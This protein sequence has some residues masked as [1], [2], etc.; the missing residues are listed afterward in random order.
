MV[1]SVNSVTMTATDG[2]GKFASTTRVISLVEPAGN[3]APT[4]TF[5]VSCVALACLTSSAGTFDANGDVIRYSRNFGDASALS[6]ATSPSHTYLANGTYTITL[7]TTDARD[8]TRQLRL[9]GAR[10]PPNP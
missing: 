7:T 4:P 6:T 3:V 5:T 9:L 2:W 1:C 8:A 10:F